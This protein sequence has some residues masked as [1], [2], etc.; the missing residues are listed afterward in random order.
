MKDVI[1]NQELIF[2]IDSNTGVY[3]PQ[4]FMCKY[5]ALMQHNTEISD[6][7][8]IC[9]GTVQNGPSYGRDSED[10]WEAWI[11]IENNCTVLIDGVEYTIYHDGDIWLVHP[12]YVWPEE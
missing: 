1:A 7:Y 5:D 10:Y 12:D 2:A 4:W 11:W 9:E 8:V 6:D 3:A